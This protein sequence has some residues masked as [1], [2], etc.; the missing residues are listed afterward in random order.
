MATLKD[1]RDERL[2]KLADIKALG[3]NPYPAESH[4]TH[5]I[6]TI[7]MGFDNLENQQVTTLGRITAIRKF[8]KLAFIVIKD[9][10]ATGLQ[11]FIRADDER[12]TPDRGNF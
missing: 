3:I 1:Y 11:L 9:D 4:R 12:P 8:G 6:Q 5:D 10:S 2:R 7:V